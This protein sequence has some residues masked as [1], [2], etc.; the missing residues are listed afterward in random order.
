M[1]K[2]TKKVIG[3]GL[4][5]GSL[6]LFVIKPTMQTSSAIEDMVVKQVQTTQQQRPSELQL[7]GMGNP[8]NWY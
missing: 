1:K 6:Y 5:L 4:A 8:P 3:Y 7:Y 2:G